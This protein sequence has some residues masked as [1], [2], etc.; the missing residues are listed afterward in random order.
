MSGSEPP[1]LSKQFAYEDAIDI[2]QI[3]SGSDT[4]GELSIVAFTPATRRIKREK[5]SDTNT[6]SIAAPT[7]AYSELASTPNTLMVLTEGRAVASEIAYCYFDLTTSRC[8]LSQFADTASYSRTLYAIAAARPQA[9]LVPRAMAAGKSKAM[10]NIHRYLPW[11]AIAPLER[12]LF[13]DTEGM[14]MLKT[15]ALPGQLL[16]LSRL[17][18]CK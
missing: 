4:D 6:E 7:S 12:K 2:T 14:Q 11:A 13:D 5:D 18:H 8:M 17:L 3:D 9:I 10:V 16:P 1:S 15:M